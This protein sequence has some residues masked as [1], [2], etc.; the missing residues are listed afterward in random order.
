MP[1][2][3]DHK[4]LFLTIGWC[5]LSPV[6]AQAQVRDTVPKKERPD[7]VA[8]SASPACCAIVRIDLERSVVTAR[9]T[10]T[11]FT[12]RFQVKARRLLG[13]LKVGHPVWAD[14]S[15]RSVKLRA[16]DATPCCAIV[17]EG[18]R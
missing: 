17:T 13:T 2:P 3:M 10:A 4:S 9:E 6:S 11:G 12:F 14:F 1:R 5:L 16:T 15:A 8:R 7:A 18:T